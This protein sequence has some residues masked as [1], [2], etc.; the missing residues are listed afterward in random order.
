MSEIVYMVRN[1]WMTIV[2]P[3]LEIDLQ[4]RF[5]PCLLSNEARNGH[6]VVHR[7]SDSFMAVDGFPD[8]EWVT[9]Y[10]N[11]TIKLHCF[12]QKTENGHSRL[13]G[14][15]ERF[16]DE[17]TLVSRSYYVEGKRHGRKEMFYASGERYSLC[18]YRDGQPVREHRYYYENG[19]QKSEI[20]YVAGRIHGRV[21]LYNSKGAVKRE[22]FHD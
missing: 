17:G 22:T 9:R 3:Y 16:S 18:F 2:D 15:C 1:G 11:G 12:Y 10:S 21:V 8:G 7:G 5:D 19:Q 14:P 20:P 4:V 6:E 13:H